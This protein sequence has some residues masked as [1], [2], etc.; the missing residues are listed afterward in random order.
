LQAAE[1]GYVNAGLLLEAALQ[2][3][4]G[5]IT[6]FEGSSLDSDMFVI[7]KFLNSLGKR[8]KKIREMMSIP[9]N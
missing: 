9:L 1:A 7:E 2:H 6:C 8:L 4:H 5:G 3:A